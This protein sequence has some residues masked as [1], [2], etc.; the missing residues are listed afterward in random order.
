GR[1]VDGRGRG[2]GRLRL[3]PLPRRP[4]RLGQAARRVVGLSHGGVGSRD[5]TMLAHHVRS[6]PRRVQ[7]AGG[8]RA[9][10]LETSGRVLLGAARQRSGHARLRAVRPRDGARRPS[11]LPLVAIRSRGCRRRRPGATAHR[12]VGRPAVAPGDI[13]DLRDPRDDLRGV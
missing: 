8:P 5:G 6:C 11:G 1:V 13:R 12:L 7:R 10:A 3:G 4:T 9:R 2:C